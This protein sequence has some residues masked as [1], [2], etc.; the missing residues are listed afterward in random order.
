MRRGTPL[1]AMIP[2]IHFF[3][4]GSPKAQPRA[5]SFAIQI[6]GKWTAR[7]YDPGSAEAWK[8][9]I[10]E[11]GKEHLPHKPIEGPVRLDLVFTF[12]RPRSHF[13]TGRYR[14]VLR[15]DAPYWYCVLKNDRDNC[16]KAVMDCLKILGFFKDDGQVCHGFIIRCYGDKPG[17]DIKLASLEQPGVRPQWRDDPY[18]VPESGVLL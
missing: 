2:E 18:R 10:A 8:T 3:V 6:A 7:A 14:G 11:V 5:R 13:R 1:D 12:P 9:R 4:S 15:A 17:A 16:D